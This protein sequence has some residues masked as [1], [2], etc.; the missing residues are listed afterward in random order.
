MNKAILILSYIIVH[1]FSYG[2]GFN[3]IW[4]LGDNSL[5]PFPA[6][7]R[8]FIDSNSYNIITESRKMD[9]LGTEGNICNANGNFL[10][11][12][13]GV[14]IADATNDTMMNGD[15]I[16]PNGV[17]SSWPFG[18]PYFANNIFLNY[19]GDS[20]KYI[21]FHHTITQVGSYYHC[22]E[23][24]S[25]VIDVTLNSGLGG[26]TL[27]N[28]VVIQ[29]T[30]N[31]GIG[32]CKHAN[33]SDW[34]IVMMKDASDIAYTVLCD[35]SGIAT[36]FKQHLNYNPLPVENGAQLSFSLDGTKFI[37]TTYDNPTNQNSFLV[38]ADFDRCT[39]MFSNT[40]T[41][42]LTNGSYLWGL[43]FSPSGK[44]AYAC[45]SGYIFQ[46]DVDNLT[47]DTVATYDGFI[48]P[49]TSTCCATTFW[50]MYLAANG[51]IYVTSGS[52]VRHFTE[53]N[54]P[55]SADTACNV[56]QHS[57][58]IGNYPH[59]RAVPNHPNYY[60]GCDTTGGCTC[61]TGINENQQN[62]FRFRIYPNPVT[63][64]YLHIGYLLPQNKKGLFQ[65]YDITGKVVFKY[66]LPQWSNEQSFKLPEL[67]EG[68]YNC[69]ITS[70][71]ERVSKKI[72]VI[73]E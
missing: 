49:P 6:N 69:I 51:K 13:N 5:A 63:E 53:I 57:V 38:I 33:G 39:G 24:Y 43:A 17:T 66:G 56:Q 1:N 34:W 64:G 7:G 11:S 65:I 54:Y 16:N 41:I 20:T 62:D 58:F 18:L 22:F 31:E 42:Q 44:Y 32:A 23:L 9:F 55:D 72:A 45:S 14:W 12:S 3:H 47:V 37:T 30:L 46:V 15:S 73:N 27:K 67:S 10:M 2:Q 61:L 52:R 28:S 60:L 71:M 48:S 8:M 29:D 70:G 40:Q 36:V 50:N 35:S 26:V 4:L 21:L 68:I 19:P 25:S 59:L